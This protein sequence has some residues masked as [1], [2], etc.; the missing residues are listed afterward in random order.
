MITAF[1][2]RKIPA[3][4]GNFRELENFGGH[5]SFKSGYH[6]GSEQCKST[7]NKQKKKNSL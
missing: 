6:N 4:V 2:K 1:D 3:R 5:F 7:K